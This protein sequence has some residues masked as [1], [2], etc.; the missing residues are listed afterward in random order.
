MF[1][2]CPHCGFLVAL[3]VTERGGRTR[4]PRCEKILEPHPG[5]AATSAPVI[6]ARADEDPRTDP[7]AMSDDRVMRADN[8]GHAETPVQPRAATAEL[9]ASSARPDKDVPPVSKNRTT[10]RPPS[11]LRTIGAPPRP[12]GRRWPGIAAA[13]LLAIVLVVQLLLA[14]R[15]E[16]A[17]SERWRPLAAALCGVLGCEIPLWHEPAAYT[18][19]ARDVKP[20]AG[21]AGELLVR[22]SFRNDAHWPQAWPSLQLQLT[23]INGRP[24][25]ARVLSPSEYHPSDV[26]P[27]QPLAPGQSASVEFRVQEPA[28]PIV[29]FDFN[30]R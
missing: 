22:A 4:C 18:M 20:A 1:V 25:A 26:P 7:V 28:T 8:V 16:L 3:I 14:Q 12:G 27:P 30:F 21:R 29:A 17:A 9:K 23:D 6:A 13:A 15:N 24:V 2:P 5:Q 11:F 10:A 19:L